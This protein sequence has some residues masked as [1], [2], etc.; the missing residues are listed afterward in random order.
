[1]ETII[2]IY[3]YIEEIEEVERR[4]MK[5]VPWIERYEYKNCI[6]T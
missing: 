5:N 6:K 3:N 4:P 1:M 2:R